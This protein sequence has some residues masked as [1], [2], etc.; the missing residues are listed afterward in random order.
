MFPSAYVRDALFIPS[1]TWLA[2]VVTGRQNDA[3]IIMSLVE[4]TSADT[5]GRPCPG[6]HALKPV[7]SAHA[8]PPGGTGS[9]GRGHPGL[10]DNPAEADR[11]QHLACAQDFHPD[12]DLH[13]NAA[14]G[15]ELGKKGVNDL[16]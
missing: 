13:P 14:Q 8:R 5:G 11:A 2:R 1:E 3:E 7:P 15:P 16:N 12:A 4:M 9:P 6:C 10:G